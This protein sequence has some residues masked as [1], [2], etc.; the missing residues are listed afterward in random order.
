MNLGTARIVIIVVFVAVGIVV[1]TNGFDG[2][3]SAVSNAG[4]LGGSTPTESPSATPS[5]SPTTPPRETPSP[6]VDGVLI[7][8][9]NGTSETGLAG[10]VQQ[11]LEAENYIAAQEAA[12]SPVSPL[13]RTTIYYRGGPDAAQNRSNAKHLAETYLDGAK[14]TRLGPDQS[15]VV[16]ASA[17]IAIFLGVDYVEA[18]A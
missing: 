5:A 15:D 7:A 4:D 12:N 16:G 1:L 13:P 6:Q 14:V 18:N 17:Q 2:D 8:V 9:F 11:M 3:T 10:Q